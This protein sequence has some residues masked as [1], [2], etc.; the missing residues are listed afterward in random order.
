MSFSHYS[1]FEGWFTLECDHPYI[2]TE[3]LTERKHTFGLFQ[4]CFIETYTSAEGHLHY[5][6][7]CRDRQVQ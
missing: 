7:G 2:T 1:T 6:S 5:R 3:T 4:M